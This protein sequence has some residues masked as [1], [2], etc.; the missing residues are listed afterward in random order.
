MEQIINQLMHNF[1]FSLM[2]ILNVVTYVLIK[3]VD[4]INKEK[5]VTTWQKRIIFVCVSIIIGC[6]YYFLSDV[7]PIVIINSIIIAPIAWSWLAK[8]IADR[9]G[10]DYKHKYK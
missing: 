3:F 5:I 9:L 6:I 7:K 2:F 10:I 8:P 1:D 4:E